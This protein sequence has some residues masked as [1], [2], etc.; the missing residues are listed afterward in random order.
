MS[1]KKRRAAS[2]EADASSSASSSAGSD[3]SFDFKIV[4]PGKGKA[5]GKAGAPNP[6]PG[7][8]KAGMPK[9]APGAGKGA[10][11]SSKSSTSK[12]GAAGG[13]GAAKRP[14]TDGEPRPGK[15]A[16]SG[17][18]KAVKVKATEEDVEAAKRQSDALEAMRALG[19]LSSEAAP[20]SEDDLV[21]VP[22]AFVRC[23]NRDVKVKGGSLRNKFLFV[24]PGQ[25]AVLNAGVCGTV[26]GAG[27][28][29]PE[30]CIEDRA[31]GRTLRL[32][33][34]VTRP[35]NSY[36]VMG[37]HQKGKAVTCEPAYQDVVVLHSYR[38]E[39]TATGEPEGPAVLA[40]VDWADPPVLGTTHASISLDVPV[41]DDDNDDDDDD[42]S[43]LESGV[44]PAQS[45]RSH[46]R[47]SVTRGSASKS[48]F[49]ARRPS[50][51]ESDSEEEVDEANDSDE[52]AD[53]SE[54]KGEEQG[55][56]EREGE[57]GEE[58][59]EEYRGQASG[60]PDGDT[61]DKRAR[62]GVKLQQQ[63]KQQQQQQQQ[64][65]QQKQP[66]QQQPKPGRQQPRAAAAGR[67]NLVSLVD[68][69]DESASAAGAHEAPSQRS[70]S[71]R[72]QRA[73][74]KSYKLDSAS[75]GGDSSSGS[76]E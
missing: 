55:E 64:Q 29:A 67:D 3:S 76:S 26:Q 52:D 47:G 23:S 14:R 48:R 8:G 59:D 6:A 19:A 25:L 27:S 42:M 56:G 36:L 21:E 54:D 65:K 63:H 58:D 40:D 72:S 20:A 62:P 57:D 61:M 10:S 73:P 69:S 74:R 2:D 33:G 44:E 43:Q 50:Y 39:S 66:K 32:F 70:Q 51:L 75:D 22:R 17:A 35:S 11:N 16:G 34:A 37:F 71:Q 68:D 49:T 53:E 1:S 12:A 18:G 13:A 9:A 46:S 60:A 15:A 24:F 45:Q 7:A 5:T 28:A 41:I 31:T 38:W 4:T 30:L